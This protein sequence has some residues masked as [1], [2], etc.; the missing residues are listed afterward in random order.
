MLKIDKGGAVVAAAAR[1][2][3]PRKEGPFSPVQNVKTRGGPAIE[4]CENIVVDL[5]N[6]LSARICCI[7][8]DRLLYL[9]RK[10]N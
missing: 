1:G 3:Q 2:E 5:V 8:H 10:I 9:K 4:T 7:L 6:Q